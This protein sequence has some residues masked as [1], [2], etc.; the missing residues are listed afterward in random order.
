[1]W[2]EEIVDIMAEY[3]PDRGAL[4]YL[5]ETRERVIYTIESL[6]PLQLEGKKTCE[7]GF[8][9]V[10]LGLRHELNADVDAY[11]VNDFFAPLCLNQYIPH[12]IIDLNAPEGFQLNGSYDLIVLC[13][14]I[15]HIKEWP[16]KVLENIN[17]YL[18]PGGVLLVTTPNL[19]RLSNRLRMLAGKRIFAHFVPEEL[20]MGHLREYTPE[21][22]VFLLQ[23]AGFSNNRFELCNF[24]D[25]SRKKIEQHSYKYIVKILPRLSNYIFCWSQKERG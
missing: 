4:Q 15:E 7:I 17:K 14:V 13:E 8:G 16:V 12:F 18:K 21:E 11:D 1:M 6:R 25:T 9:A 19:H 10:G 24:P 3:C 2:F 23:K 22:L 20:L 5:H